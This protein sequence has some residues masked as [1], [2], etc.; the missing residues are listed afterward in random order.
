MPLWSTDERI[1][2]AVNIILKAMRDMPITKTRRDLLVVVMVLQCPTA[3]LNMNQREIE[4]ALGR[5][6]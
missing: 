3:E 1:D 4:N 6:L 2:I 5:K